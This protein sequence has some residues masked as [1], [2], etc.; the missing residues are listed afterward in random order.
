[1]H[2]LIF[3]K[4]LLCTVCSTVM[5]STNYNSDDNLLDILVRDNVPDQSHMFLEPQTDDAHGAVRYW[6]DKVCVNQHEF[7]NFVVAL[8]FYASNVTSMNKETGDDLGHFNVKS[9][10]V[11]MACPE[12]DVWHNL[13]VKQLFCAFA[14]HIKMHM[15][16]VWDGEHT[17]LSA[18]DR[19]LMQH[20]L[21]AWELFV[22]VAFDDPQYVDSISSRS[23]M[24]ENI[25]DKL[26]SSHNSSSN[27]SDMCNETWLRVLRRMA[28]QNFGQAHAL[29][30]M[31][32]FESIQSVCH[33]QGLLQC[34]QALSANESETMS[35]IFS[36]PRLMLLLVGT[37]VPAV[38]LNL[39][40][41]NTFYV[42]ALKGFEL[43]CDDEYIKLILGGFTCANEVGMRGIAVP[44]RLKYATALTLLCLSFMKTGVKFPIDTTTFTTPQYLE[45]KQ[46]LRDVGQFVMSTLSVNKQC[47]SRAEEN[48]WMD[49]ASHVFGG[50]DQFRDTSAAFVSP[51]NIASEQMVSLFQEAKPFM[52]RRCG[53]VASASFA[54]A[55][56]FLGEMDNERFQQDTVKQLLMA[57]E[58]LQ[59]NTVEL[60]T[61]QQFAFLL[62]LLREN[63]LMHL[64]ANF[65]NRNQQALAVAKVRKEQKWRQEDASCRIFVCSDILSLVSQLT[66][67]MQ[68]M[69]A[70]SFGLEMPSPKSAC[71][72]SFIRFVERSKASG[73]EAFKTTLQ[74]LRA[75]LFAGAK[76]ELVVPV[77]KHACTDVDLAMRNH[78]T[79][80]NTLVLKGSTSLHTPTDTDMHTILAVLFAQH[81][82]C[83]SVFDWCLQSQASSLKSKFMASSRFNPLFSQTWDTVVLDRLI[84][85]IRD[86]CIEDVHKVFASDDPVAVKQFVGQKLLS[87]FESPTLRNQLDL[88][89]TTLGN[90]S[91]NL[92]L[93][94]L[95]RFAIGF[96]HSILVTP[97]SNWSR[98]CNDV[99]TTLQMCQTSAEKQ[100]KKRAR[101]ALHI[102]VD[103]LD[104]DDDE[105]LRC[106]GQL[107]SH[108][109]SPG[110]GVPLPQSWPC[111][112]HNTEAETKPNTVF[113]TEQP[114]DNLDTFD[115]NMDVAMLSNV[116]DRATAINV[117]TQKL[118]TKKKS[119]RNTH[120][121]VSELSEIE[122]K[123]EQNIER[124]NKI[125]AQMGIQPL[126]PAK[127]T[128][129]KRTKRA[130][131]SATTS[132]KGGF[133][134]SGRISTKAAVDYTQFDAQSDDGFDF[135][136]ESD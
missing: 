5:M 102:A 135:D 73:F 22:N 55:I 110:S 123:R 8:G 114:C 48:V 50:K 41:I 19:Y 107:S 95:A 69:S 97:T 94:N 77:C 31:H 27:P 42:S 115:G 93:G 7:E 116:D 65:P 131:Q 38:L 23:D 43:C 72:G 96:M 129:H 86:K 57:D 106:I 25:M 118:V 99:V 14:R 85:N 82:M 45:F 2:A 29:L 32:T 126:K 30:D 128:C 16:A 74:P 62:H 88:Y 81:D 46:R 121:N 133:R 109:F 103:A 4:R 71:P 33:L 58:S 104:N 125:L 9:M 66:I 49:V 24:T 105:S 44:F 91:G 17:N 59:S 13:G 68:E 92:N 12:T 3:F 35:P 127:D 80:N 79:V 47:K 10:F 87:V 54:T 67:D 130:P 61:V 21:S 64:I 111:V 63:V 76:S 26:F 90:K 134:K 60:N 56:N 120:S 136:S 37:V 18:S 52:V 108:L 53:D 100:H 113:Q 70:A 122:K 28:P 36:P 83:T 39:H 51:G 11:N 89:A 34:M 112:S 124:N 132:L 20:V 119:K 40:S 6:A 15:N 101:S 78:F 84:D 75:V 1:M 117:Q 98:V